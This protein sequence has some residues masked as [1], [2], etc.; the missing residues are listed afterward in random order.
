MQV[1]TLMQQLRVNITSNRHK[2]NRFILHLSNQSL[3]RIILRSN[4]L[5]NEVLS[6]CLSDGLALGVKNSCEVIVV[7]LLSKS[8]FNEGENEDTRGEENL[9]VEVNTSDFLENV[10]VLALY[11]FEDFFDRAEAVLDVFFIS[12]SSLKE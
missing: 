9:S 8:D 3:I 5:C 2:P 12:V 6:V 4:K 1:K 11:F 10:S 7:F